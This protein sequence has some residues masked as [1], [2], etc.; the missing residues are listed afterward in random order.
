MASHETLLR[1]YLQLPDR[2]QAAIAGLD[3]AGLDLKG[4]G[5]SIRQYV[6]H[7][8]EGELIWEVNLR[9]AAGSDGI[10]FPMAWYFSQPQE[11]WAECW[12]Y[13]RRP[14]GSALALFRG[15][16]CN[17]VEYLRLVPDEV[18]NRSGRVTWPEDKDESRLTVRD[19]LVI[20]IRHMDGHTADIRAIRERYGR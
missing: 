2:L 17:L 1:K 16:T 18:W 11:A 10:E 12:A 3:D 20:H 15:S 4:D 6:H 5:W 8:V 9:A 14:V 13:D 19:I 7:V